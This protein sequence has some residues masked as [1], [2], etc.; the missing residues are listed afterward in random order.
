VTFSSIGGEFGLIDHLSK[1]AGSGSHPQLVMGIGDDAA[2]LRIAPEPHPL[3][4][5]TTDL[6]I[7]DRHFTRRWSRAEDIGIK[8]AECNLS[9]IAAMGGVPSWMFVSLVIA[10]ESDLAWCEGLYRG[11]AEAN[12][13]HGVVIAGGDTT[14]GAVNTI[15]ITLLGQVLPQNLCLRSHARPGDLLVVTGTL[16]A[17]AAALA[18]LSTGRQPG[19]YLLTKHL[20]PRCRLDISGSIAPL[21][22]A[23]IDISDGLAAEVRHICKN[24]RVGAEIDAAAVPLHPDVRQAGDLLGRDPLEFALAG[25]EDFEL[26]FSI[27]PENLAQLLKSGWELHPV[28]RITAVEGDATVIRSG[29]REP[30]TGGFDHFS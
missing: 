4:L 12:A 3:L 2:V 6:L 19:P 5:V 9:D 22:N 20:T 27:T 14:R 7:E 13:P 21:A 8:A 24:S 15:S 23:M 16:G 1:I 26:L 18:L 10:P 25:G 17:S 29:V 11:L 30:L 28:G